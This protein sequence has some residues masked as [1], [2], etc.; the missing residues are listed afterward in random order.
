MCDLEVVAFVAHR[1]SSPNPHPLQSLHLVGL[2]MS[3]LLE[4]VKIFRIFLSYVERGEQDDVAGAVAAKAST[5]LSDTTEHCV[6]GLI[7]KLV[8]DSKAG[9]L[10]ALASSI[11][12]V[13]EFC[14]ASVSTRGLLQEY[15]GVDL[16]RQVLLHPDPDYQKRY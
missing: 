8:E 5:L 1:A 7:H 2:A 11:W 16:L 13:R 4:A 15:G 3:D 9:N 6:K 10:T 14:E 12:P